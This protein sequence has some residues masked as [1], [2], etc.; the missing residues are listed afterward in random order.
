MTVARRAN[1]GRPARE[2][3]RAPNALQFRCRFTPA[4]RNAAEEAIFDDQA[5][6]APSPSQLARDTTKFLVELGVCVVDEVA[7]LGGLAAGC[8]QPRGAASGS[9]STPLQSITESRPRRAPLRQTNWLQA[10]EAR[11]P[12]SQCTAASGRSGRI[13]ARCGSKAVLPDAGHIH[14]DRKHGTG[15]RLSA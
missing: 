6:C 8:P 7:D 1:H 4:L 5:G 12:S 13:A 3:Q 10:R 11:R 2:D 9:T 15:Q 14:L